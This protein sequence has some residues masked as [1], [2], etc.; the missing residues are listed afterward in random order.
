MTRSFTL[1]GLLLLLSSLCY[2]Q[3][4]FRKGFIV[5]H[6]KDTVFG[7]AQFYDGAKAFSQCSFRRSSSDEPQT[8]EPDDLLGYGFVDGRHFISKVV[9]VDGTKQAEFMEVLVAGH[10]TLYRLRDTFWA[11]KDSLVL[12]RNDE[13]EFYKDN[14]HYRKRSKEYIGTLSIIMSDCPKLNATI[15]KAE[16]RASDLAK[17]IES[18]NRCQS[19]EVNVYNAK[20]PWIKLIVGLTGGLEWSSL[21]FDAQNYFDG[22]QV[23]PYNNSAAPMI[24]VSLDVAAPRLSERFYFTTALLYASRQ[25]LFT[26]T[27]RNL[28]TNYVTIDLDELRIPLGIRYT[29]APRI[30]TPF[31][32]GG[33]SP[34]LHIKSSSGWTK[35][36][37]SRDL[38]QIFDRGEVPI[39]SNQVGFWGGVGMLLRINEKLDA[40]IEGRCELTN[41]VVDLLY[42]SDFTSN[43]TNV[44]LLVGIRIK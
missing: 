29:F 41:G 27:T 34:T 30:I 25:Y 21:S 2:A 32:N 24:G 8:Y 16:L 42:K 35:E 11:E 40:S 13:R 1:L 6:E 37:V 43:V 15:Q 7:F 9:S 14:D 44:Q 22:D 33:I 5:R 28:T 18:Y 36:L 12:L 3:T 39:K 31:L 17:L 26:G 38:V 19:G 4:D 23:V 10:A 20:K